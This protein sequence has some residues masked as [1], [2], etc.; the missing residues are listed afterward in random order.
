MYQIVN[1]LTKCNFTN[2]DNPKRVE[3]IVIHY[4]GGLSTAESVASWFQNPAAGVSAHLSVDE[5]PL[6]YRSVEDGDVAWHCGTKG[7]YYHPHCRNS[8]SIG[9]E[10]RPYAL[11]K[12]KATNS[13]YNGWYFGTEVEDRL[14]EVVKDLMK[15]YNIPVDR[16]LRH[17]DVTHKLCPRPWVGKDINPYYKTSGDV[18]WLRFKKRLVETKKDEEDEEMD[19]NKFNEMFLVAM[20]ATN[21]TFGDIK[22]V[23]EYWRPTIQKLMDLGLI[24]GGT[25]A[26]LN[27][28]D[29][30]LSEDTIKAIVILVGYINKLLEGK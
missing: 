14:V 13:D 6:V 11:D 4:F 29:V 8:N 15:K 5:R 10:V 23:P 25:A 26:T 3:Y 28:H 27:A 21:P 1:R 17:Y 9:I 30:N 16:V 19:Q 18:Q 22:S 24:N 7:T 20:K 2:K 12:A